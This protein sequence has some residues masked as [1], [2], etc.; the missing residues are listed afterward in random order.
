MLAC[1]GCRTP[2]SA[3]GQS[4]PPTSTTARI[5]LARVHAEAEVDAD[6][7]IMLVAHAIAQSRELALGESADAVDITDSVIAALAR[8]PLA[9]LPWLVGAWQSEADG[10]T[11]T[12]RWCPGED[13]T[14]FGYNTTEQ[15]GK[16]VAFEWLTIAL[17]P[18]G[19]VYLAQPEG[20]TP[21]TPFA[22]V[23][24]E[25]ARF[26]NPSNEFPQR[27]QY[28]PETDAL[29]VVVSAG[30]QK[31]EWTWRRVGDAQTL[32]KDCASVRA[33]EHP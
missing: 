13:G 19:I 12:E 20:R 31:L 27:L 15:G 30:E 5:D 10:M 14:L 8:E 32:A 23:D 25:G 18:N 3:R 33:H 28:T 7:A 6:L 26:E 9:K 21:A 11:T 1:L 29:Q 16:R 2:I 4:P 24:G 22:F 17:Q